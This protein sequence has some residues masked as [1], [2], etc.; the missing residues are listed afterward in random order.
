MY[1]YVFEIKK[2]GSIGLVRGEFGRNF[3]YLGVQASAPLSHVPFR[4]DV[5][6]LRGQHHVKISELGLGMNIG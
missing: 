1:I 5:I 4:G 3:T 6:L 2:R